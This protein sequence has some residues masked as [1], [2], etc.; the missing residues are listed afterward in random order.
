V[1]TPSLKG[2]MLIAQSGGPSMVINQ[3]LVGAVLEAKKQRKIGKILGALHGIRGVLEGKLV[4]LR[5]ESAANLEAV[6]ARPPRRWVGPEETLARGLREDLRGA[7]AARRA[8]L[9]L[10]RRQR[11]GGDRVHHQRR[12][13]TA[14]YALRCYHIPKTIDN[15]LLENDHTPASAARPSSSPAP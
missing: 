12:S 8:L 6:A 7:Q 14:R 11:L 9:L 2:N 10:H 15:D 5:K 13:R 3:S 4:D 1:A